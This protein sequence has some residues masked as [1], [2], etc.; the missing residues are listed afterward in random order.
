MRVRLKYVVLSGRFGSTTVEQPI[1]F[2]ERMTHSLVA[3]ALAKTEDFKTA[4]DV[5]PVAAGD[6]TFELTIANLRG[7]RLHCS[8]ESNTLKLKSRGQVD[9]DLIMSINYLHGITEG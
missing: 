8:G 3:S 7:H 4:T 1:L 9:A 2:P 6:V 5:K